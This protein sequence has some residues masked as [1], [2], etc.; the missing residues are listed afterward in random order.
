MS[1]VIKFL[2]T[3]FY[4]HRAVVEAKCVS[5]LHLPTQIEHQIQREYRYT[6]NGLGVNSLP[7]Q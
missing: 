1:T 4:L 5:G 2:G 3:S 6:A 7:G